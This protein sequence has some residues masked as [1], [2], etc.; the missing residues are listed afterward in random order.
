MGMGI[1]FAT[2]PPGTDQA[3]SPAVRTLPRIDVEQRPE[4]LLPE[5]LPGH[6]AHSG[7]LAAGAERVWSGAA[8]PRDLTRG[9]Q[10]QLSA[11]HRL[12]GTDKADRSRHSRYDSVQASRGFIL[13]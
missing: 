5:P 3:L 10:Q 7:R 2:L 8:L 12:A 13:L 11:S 1:V 4:L 9:H 6:S